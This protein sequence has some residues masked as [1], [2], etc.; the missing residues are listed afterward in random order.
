VIPAPTLIPGEVLAQR[1]LVIAFGASLLKASGPAG[2]QVPE[3]LTDADTVSFLVRIEN[4][5]NAGTLRLSA[6]G[7]VAIPLSPGVWAIHTG[8]N[9]ILSPGEVDAGLGLKGL[10]E[11][12]I[13]GAFAANLQAV[14]G[15]RSAGVFDKPLGRR[16]GMPRGQTDRASSSRM[17]QRGQHFEFTVH[18]RPGDRLSL[19]AMVAQS[20]DGLIATGRDGIEL[21]D[22]AGRPISGEVTSQLSLWDAGTEVN[23]EPGTGRNQGLRQGAPH[24][25]DPERN[26]V[27]P[28][29]EAEFGQLWPPT[30]KMVRVTISPGDSK[31]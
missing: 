18:A 22:A 15:V 7:A 11:A 20:N 21:F 1:L 13:A 23:E 14:P 29:S 25:G 26:P 30:V 4:V 27:R 8:A 10:A 24:A 16:R 12:G 9:P 19:A 3:R 31:S 2:A 28:M 17:L 6:G 5:S